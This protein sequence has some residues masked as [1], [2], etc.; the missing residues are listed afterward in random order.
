M[1]CNTC[2][3]ALFNLD[4]KSP[5]Y[6]NPLP[7]SHGTG[8]GVWMNQALT[9]QARQG[10]R[11]LPP[12]LQV[13]PLIVEVTSLKTN[14][15]GLRSLYSPGKT[16]AWLSP[17][18]RLLVVTAPMLLITMT[19]NPYCTDSKP[20][21]LDCKPFH[22]YLRFRVLPARGSGF[23]GNHKTSVKQIFCFFVQR[24]GERSFVTVFV[25]SLIRAIA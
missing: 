9:S 11:Q 6:S 17:Q 10:P 13:V 24:E 21:T 12:S 16:I 4:P 25:R 23:Q 18:T 2:W 20:K 15:V 14:I 19:V 22:A 5:K 1:V 8:F 7:A 3:L